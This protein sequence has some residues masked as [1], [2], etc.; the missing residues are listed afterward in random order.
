MEAF[1][2]VSVNYYCIFFVLLMQVL[3]AVQKA[4]VCNICFIFNC[5]SNV[6]SVLVMSARM[7][8]LFTPIKPALRKFYHLNKAHLIINN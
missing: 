7:L 6:N 2:F 1:E 3:C 5:F 4:R 8:P